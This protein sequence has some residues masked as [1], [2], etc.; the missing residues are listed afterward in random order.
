MKVKV[1]D[2]VF[3][4][5]QRINSIKNGGGRCSSCCWRKDIYNM[6][7]EFMHSKCNNPNHQFRIGS[8]EIAKSSVCL[9]FKRGNGSEK[10]MKENCCFT[11]NLEETEEE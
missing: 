2:L 1:P 7:D 9:D 5:T 10:K 11:S 3:S 4:T 6:L 8:L